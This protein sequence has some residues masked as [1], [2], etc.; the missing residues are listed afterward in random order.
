MSYRY[1]LK[2]QGV[3]GGASD[4]LY[5]G[6]IELEGIRIG[7]EGV[8]SHGGGGGGGR[9]GRHL[10]EIA[11]FKRPDSTSMV[12]FNAAHNGRPFPEATLT[13]E[14][15]LFFGLRIRAAEIK[16]HAVYIESVL[17]GPMLDE[18]VLNFDGVRF[19]SGG[20]QSLEDVGRQI[21]KRDLH[22]GHGS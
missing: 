13:I 6:A 1:F 14:R 2:I 9:T 7:V 16:M 20:L 15:E 4:P 22:R 8:P 5:A 12:L 3:H 17:Q 21:P 18:I 11:V 10:R 19:H